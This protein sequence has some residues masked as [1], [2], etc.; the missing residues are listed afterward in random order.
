M[1][2]GVKA[3]LAKQL[4]KRILFDIMRFELKHCNTNV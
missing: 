3:L 4:R 2:L 1:F